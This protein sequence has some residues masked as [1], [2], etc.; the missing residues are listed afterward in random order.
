MHDH[1]F[2]GIKETLI[3]VILYIHKQL[4]AQRKY[5]SFNKLAIWLALGVQRSSLP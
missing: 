4:R 1:E 5:L 2:K 3:G